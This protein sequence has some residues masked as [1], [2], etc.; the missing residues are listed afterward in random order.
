M[1]GLRRRLLG[2]RL[3]LVLVRLGG[4]SVHDAQP[5]ERGLHLNLSHHSACLQEGGFSDVNWTWGADQGTIGY[6][7]G[8]C[9]EWAVEAT[10]W[11]LAESDSD[12]P[13]NVPGSCPYG[14]PMDF[15]SVMMLGTT[16][17]WGGG[18]Q[19]AAQWFNNAAE[20]HIC[21]AYDAEN[22]E[23]NLVRTVCGG[24][25]N[26]FGCDLLAGIRWFR[27]QDGMVFGAQQGTNNPSYAGD[28]IFLNDHITNDLIGFQVGCNASYRFA[29]CWKVFVIPKIGIYDN[30]M[31][32]DYNLYGVDNSCNYY[33]G[34][35]Q[36]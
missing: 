3:L 5:A 1:R 9:C 16:G 2:Q 14:T 23:V 20:N 8:S 30:H 29:D 4:R 11:D 24:P 10:Y 19:S 26:R 6:R 33:Q 13:P 22:L 34:A 36:L 21:R 18:C 17:G 27:F 28:W 7:F 25:C 32:L 35:S 31:T 12:G 15:R